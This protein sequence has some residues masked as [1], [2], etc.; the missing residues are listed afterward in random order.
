MNVKPVEMICFKNIYKYW[1]PASI[2]NMFGKR[3]KQNKSSSRFRYKI[4]WI[5]ISVRTNNAKNINPDY[6]RDYQNA[7]TLKLNNIKRVGCFQSLFPS[8]SRSEVR[9]TLL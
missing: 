8:V 4:F 2:F 1:I 5:F 3:I 7:K 6:P 9:T